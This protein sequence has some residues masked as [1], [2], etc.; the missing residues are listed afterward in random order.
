[1]QCSMMISIYHSRWFIQTMSEKTSIPFFSIHS[2]KCPQF[3]EIYSFA[4]WVSILHPPHSPSVSLSFS[5]FQMSTLLAK[6]FPI[7]LM[8][9]ST[10]LFLNV[11]NR[12]ND[13]ILHT[14]SKRNHNFSRHQWHFQ[15]QMIYEKVSNCDLLWLYIRIQW[16]EREHFSS[17]G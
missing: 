11:F 2:S 5:R 12:Q 13:W 10:L 1:M 7:L 9:A 6:A 3:I 17:R 16:L 4:V 14:E 8:H 15:V